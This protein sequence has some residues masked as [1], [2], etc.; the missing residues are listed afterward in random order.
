MGEK[1][2]RGALLEKR[3]VFFVGY[4]SGFGVWEDYYRG[5]PGCWE[6]WARG[7]GNPHGIPGARE[8]DRLCS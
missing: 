8:L 5:A 1:F 2:G 4:F 7:A 6:F 3:T